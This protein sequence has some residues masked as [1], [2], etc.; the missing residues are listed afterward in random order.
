VPKGKEGRRIKKPDTY[1]ALRDKG[2]PRKGQPR[3][4]THRR[5]SSPTA[6]RRRSAESGAADN[7]GMR[8]WEA[9]Q[10]GRAEESWTTECDASRH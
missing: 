7:D 1:E 5:T 4:R 10:D 2:C 9:C 6:S 3:S 8:W